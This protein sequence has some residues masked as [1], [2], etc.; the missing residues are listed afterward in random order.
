[1][2]KVCINFFKLSMTLTLLWLLWTN[3]IRLVIFD[4]LIAIVLFII[5]YNLHFYIGKYLKVRRERKN[6]ELIIESL[7]KCIERQN[8]Q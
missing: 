2:K 4:I 3:D 7:Q 6:L 1:M 8:I 5:L